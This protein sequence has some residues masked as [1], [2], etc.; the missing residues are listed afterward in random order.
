ML[1]SPRDIILKLLLAAE[2]DDLSSRE[3]TG[4]CSLFGISE[5]HMRVALVRLASAGLIEASA[6]GSYRLGPKA[7]GLA[8]DVATWRAGERRVRPWKGHWIIAQTAELGRRDRPALRVRERAL[9]LLGMHALDQGVYLRPDNLSGGVAAARARLYALGLEP[10]AAIYVAFELDAEREQRARRCWDG[11][12]L[13]RA[14]G[15]TSR[16]LEAWMARA[17]ALDLESAARESYLIGDEAI[18]QLVFDPLL[19]DPLVDTAARAAFTET[20]LRY[21]RYGHDIWRRLAA[22]APAARGRRRPASSRTELH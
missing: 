12:A 4:A 10:E 14:Y 22:G 16:K 21:D 15:Q 7:V 19:P 17:D 11:K 6:R 13:S 2:G 18:R 20:V 3:F 9:S 8:G 5:S 1:P